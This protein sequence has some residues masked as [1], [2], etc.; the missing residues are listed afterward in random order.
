MAGCGAWSREIVVEKQ[1]MGEEEFLS[2]MTMCRIMPGANQM[3][4]A[5][6]IGTKMRGAPGA[7]AALVGL[8]LVPVA[9]ILT[10]GF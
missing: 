8:C 1:W 6:F 3:N 7:I 4:L 2:A 9:I 5:V 10:L